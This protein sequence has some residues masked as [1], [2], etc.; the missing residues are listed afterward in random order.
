[1]F[2]K[3]DFEPLWIVF[4]Q[5]SPP[6]FCKQSIILNIEGCIGTDLNNKVIHYETL[7][8]QNNLDSFKDPESLTLI[9]IVTIEDPNSN[10]LNYHQ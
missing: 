6:P 3:D 2:V 7:L 8:L 5:L 1:M 10:Y 9:K 4:S